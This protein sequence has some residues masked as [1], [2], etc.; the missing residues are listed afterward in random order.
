VDTEQEKRNIFSKASSSS[1]SGSEQHPDE[2]LKGIDVCK[3]KLCEL[4]EKLKKL[5][6]QLKQ[7]QTLLVES[8]EALQSEA[9]IKWCD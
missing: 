9:G 5:M 6:G 3:S 1:N 7:N 8:Q 2:I 4:E